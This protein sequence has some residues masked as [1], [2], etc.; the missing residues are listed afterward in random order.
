MII[1]F[2]TPLQP[3]QSVI[4]KMDFVDKLPLT[5]EQNYGV[6]AYYDN[7]L[8][9]AH[10]YPMICVYNEEGWN[11]EIPPQSGDVTFADASFF[12]V[13]ITAPKALTLVTTGSEISHQDSN[14]TQPV[15]VAE[16]PARDF[17]LAAS[18]DYKKVS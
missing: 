13:K 18:P 9:L 14:Q 6:L 3:N 15:I 17:Y 12:V 11:A 4:L 2:S 10:F 8:A 5:V 1:P 7:V 16:G